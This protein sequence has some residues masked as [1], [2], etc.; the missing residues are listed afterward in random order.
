M[1]KYAIPLEA[2]TEIYR[3]PRS[4]RAS[5]YFICGQRGR[6][7]ISSQARKSMFIAA[8]GER[9]DCGVLF[10]HALLECPIAFS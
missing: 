7:L 5:I 1:G 8:L 6:S 9:L 2:I 10:V 4:C 3:G